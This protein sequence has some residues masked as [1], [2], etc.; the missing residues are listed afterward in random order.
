MRVLTRAPIRTPV[1]H[2][3]SRGSKTFTYHAWGASCMLPH[4]PF[5]FLNTFH[6]HPYPLSHR[7]LTPPRVR[8]RRV[9]K[10]LPLSGVSRKT[11]APSL[12]SRQMRKQKTCRKPSVPGNSPAFPDDVDPH[13]LGLVGLAEDADARKLEPSSIDVHEQGGALSVVGAA[14]AL[15]ESTAG[16]VERAAAARP[17]ALAPWSQGEAGCEAETS[18]REGEQELKALPHQGRRKPEALPPEGE[19]ECGTTPQDNPNE[20]DREPNWPPRKPS[21][22]CPLGRDQAFGIL[23]GSRRG[24]AISSRKGLLRP[25]TP[26]QASTPTTKRR[27]GIVACKTKKKKPWACKV[28]QA[29][30]PRGVNHAPWPMHPSAHP[31]AEDPTRFSFRGPSRGATSSWK[32]PRIAT[33]PFVGRSHAVTRIPARNTIL[34]R[35]HSGGGAFRCCSTQTSFI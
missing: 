28:S 8:I 29:T 13:P 12:G 24:S 20:G 16:E 11:V 25:W 27:S 32:I 17:E 19:R 2:H 1:Q 30:P 23:E 10:A 18:P 22:S 5:N 33:R 14:P 4:L 9:E 15:A 7:H 35:P 26:H 31:V 34:A 21:H 3:S 6:F